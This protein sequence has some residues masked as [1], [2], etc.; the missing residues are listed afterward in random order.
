MDEILND[1]EN[2]IAVID[3]LRGMD[4]KLEKKG[5][6]FFPRYTFSE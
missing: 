5:F 2:I 3:A 6:L 4:L 1:E